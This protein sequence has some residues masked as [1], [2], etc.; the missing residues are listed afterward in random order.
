MT[1]SLEDQIVETTEVRR[2]N[3]QCEYGEWM[4]LSDAP[5]HVQEAVSDE[6]AERMHADMRREKVRT[7]TDDSGMVDIGGEKW[8]Y[9]R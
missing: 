6:I 1:K 7:N 4:E 9:R 5:E 8:V 2:Q 3:G